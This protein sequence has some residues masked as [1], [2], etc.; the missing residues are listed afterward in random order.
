MSWVKEC[1]IDIGCETCLVTGIENDRLRAEVM[2]C[3]ELVVELAFERAK[4]RDQARQWKIVVMIGA[5]GVFVMAVA[6]W[7]K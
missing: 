1:G 2:E 3:E 6:G 5:A 7:I 4:Y